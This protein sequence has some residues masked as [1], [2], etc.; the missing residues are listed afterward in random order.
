MVDR[1]TGGRLGVSQTLGLESCPFTDLLFPE[2]TLDT[3]PCWQ[4]SVTIP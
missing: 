4:S 2:P 3:V 1:L